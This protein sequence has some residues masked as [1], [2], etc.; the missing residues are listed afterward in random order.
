MRLFNDVLRKT[1]SRLTEPDKVH[2]QVQE[3]QNR[4]RGGPSQFEYFRFNVEKGLG[5]IAMDETKTPTFATIRQ[6]TREELSKPEVK[7]QLSK[8]AELLVE[9]RRARIRDDPDRWDRFAC[10]TTYSC[11]EEECR[12]EPGEPLTFAL[13]REMRDHLLVKHRWA[14]EPLEEEGSI[15]D[16]EGDPDVFESEGG[17][18]FSK[19]EG[20]WK[21]YKPEKKGQE[22]SKLQKKLDQCRKEPEVP[23]GPF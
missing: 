15:F 4:E 8:L 21:S 20:K 3:T 11:S 19:S 2:I 9:H 17:S 10:C 7:N 22:S 13:R 5:K 18:V 14:Q 23:G 12:T 16:S 1:K 6:Y